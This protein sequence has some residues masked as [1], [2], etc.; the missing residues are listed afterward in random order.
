MIYVKYKND[1]VL[2]TFEKLPSRWTQ[3]DGTWIVGFNNLS[4]VRLALFNVYL[5]EKPDLGEF[6]KYGVPVLDN[7]TKI[8]SFPI[9][10]MTNEEIQA[11]TEPLAKITRDSV[12]IAPIFVHNALWAVKDIDRNRMKE[13]I[14]TAIRQSYPEETTIGWITED[15]GIRA[16]TRAEL[17][18][19]LDAFSVRRQSIF[20][21]YGGWF[22]GNRLAHFTGA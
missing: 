21:S 7:E 2:E 17:E 6:E 20:V 12:E 19:V 16:T 9:I 22:L 14:D 15:L 1:E 10:S 11:I 8:V 5:A 18:G 13:T 4:K 3:S